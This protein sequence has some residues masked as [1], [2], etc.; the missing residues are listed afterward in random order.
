MGTL[1]NNTHARQQAL[2]CWA[3]RLLHVAGGSKRSLPYPHSGLSVPSNGTILSQLVLRAGAGLGLPPCVLCGCC[4][5]LK[6]V[7]PLL[8][9][10]CS[11]QACMCLLEP[12]ASSVPSGCHPAVPG[13]DLQWLLQPFSSSCWLRSSLPLVGWGAAPVLSAGILPSM[14]EGSKAEGL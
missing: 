6:A 11:P 2:P 3:S 13:Y 7:S 4:E 14:K 10:A 1:W 12:S 5:L 8:C 9:P